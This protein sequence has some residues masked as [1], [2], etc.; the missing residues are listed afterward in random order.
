MLFTMIA[1]SGTVLSPLC[2]NIF[3]T[4]KLKSLVVYAELILR[5]VLLKTYVTLLLFN[6]M[7]KNRKK[8]KITTMRFWNN[9]NSNTKYVLLFL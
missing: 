6:L 1:T 5:G 9:K 3:H 8:S 7:R 2:N 4:T